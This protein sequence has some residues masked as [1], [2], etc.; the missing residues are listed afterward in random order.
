MA[1]SRQLRFC[2]L[3]AAAPL[4]THLLET[5]DG[6]ATIRAFGWRDAY[7]KASLELLDASQRPHYLLLCVQRWLGLVLNLFVAGLAMI[8]VA[9][10]VFVPGGSTVGFMALAITNMLGLGR[11][12]V[13]LV[14]S[15]T[16]LETSLGALSR[17]RDFEANTPR[18]PVP[19]NPEKPPHRWPSNGEIELREVTA[20]YNT[21]ADPVLNQISLTIKKGEKL[22]ICGRTGSGKSSLL[23]TLFRLLDLDTGSITVDGMDISHI[24]QNEVRRRL[25]SVPQ[26]PTIFPGTVR[27]NLWLPD[28]DDSDG[29]PCPT[30]EQMQ[31]ALE[32]VELWDVIST[33][34]DNG[35]DTDMATVTLSLGQKQLF[36]LCRAVLRRETSAVLVLDEAM[37]AV[38]GQ[39]ESVMVRVLE[40][41]FAQH[42]VISVAHRLNTVRKF[43]RVV[44]LDKGRVVE[45]GE[46]NALLDKV[47][48]RF[49]A[50]W[51]RQG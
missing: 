6:L 12:L 40:T 44:V 5:V 19:A 33:Q 38:D 28:G 2:D 36:C 25:I 24:P 48:G 34:G 45:V 20:S 26:E 35:F 11:S 3:Q 18:E 22:A 39:T 14:A 8:L 23:L 16:S 51:N 1:T 30:D 9:L 17:I 10:G 29:N 42:T 13:L 50:L 32:L 37:G 47:D 15:W 7:R 46:P 41:E 31:T 49:R 21:T 4:N 43:D 27:S